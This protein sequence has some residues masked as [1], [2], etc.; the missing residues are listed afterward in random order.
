MNERYF[1]R[2]VDVGTSINHENNRFQK[3]VFSAEQ[4]NDNK[5]FSL[6]QLNGHQTIWQLQLYG[7]QLAAPIVEISKYLKIK[8][9]ESNYKTMFGFG[10]SL[11]EGRRSRW[12]VWT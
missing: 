4:Q 12:E 8:I 1:V 3:Q 9:V 6:I 7:Y 2:I 10:Y 11:K 5:S